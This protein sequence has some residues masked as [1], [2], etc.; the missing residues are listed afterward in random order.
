[1]IYGQK[2]KVRGKYP[3]P[4]DMLRHDY[5]WPASEEDSGKISRTFEDTAKMEV[6]EIELR[7]EVGNK[8][9]LPTS[10]RWESFLWKVVEGSVETWR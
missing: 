9:F 8:K 1:M 10:G 2:F 7:R 3:F 4:V 5:C 6:V